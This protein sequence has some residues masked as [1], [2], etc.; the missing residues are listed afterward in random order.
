MIWSSVLHADAIVRTWLSAWHAPWLDGLM[1][2]LSG[3]DRGGLVWLAIGVPLTLRR[4]L[5]TAALWQLVLAIVLA[6]VVSDAVLKPLVNRPRPFVAEPGVVRVVGGIPRGGSFPSSHAAVAFAGAWVLA[7]YWPAGRLVLWPLA[8][9]I[10]YSRV[11]VGAHYPL[12]VVAGALLGWGIGWLAVGGA[13]GV[14][15]ESTGSDDHGPSGG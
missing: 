2:S 13:A 6:L 14:R 10:G 8:V 15:V 9:L 5:R 11:Y 7:Q 4:R 12:D 3:I 1:T